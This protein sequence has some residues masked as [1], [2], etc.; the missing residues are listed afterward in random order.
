MTEITPTQTTQTQALQ[1][2]N[3]SDRE[4]SFVPFGSEESIKLNVSI[5]QNLCAVKTKSGRTCS[6]TDAIKFIM[7]CKARGLNPFE[8]DAYLIGY[9][10]RSP[11][12]GAIVP[13]YSLITAHQAFLKRAEL[14]PEYDGMKSGLI[15]L[16]NEDTFR[17]IEGIVCLP[18]DTVYG[19]WCTVFF[20]TRKTP[21]TVRVPLSTYNTNQSRWEKDPHGMIQ[22]V[23]ESQALRKAFPTKMG[24]MFLDSEYNP[25]KTIELVPQI[26]VPGNGL[27]DTVQSED[28]P[29]TKAKEPEKEKAQ[30]P[31]PKP[32]TAKQ[33][34]ESLVLSNGHDFEN[35][36]RWLVDSGA[37]DNADSYANF[38]QIPE[39]LAKRIMRASGPLLKGL[40]AYKQQP[41]TKPEEKA[42]A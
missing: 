42:A 4:V 24:G 6:E 32:Q 15:L 30:S 14:H 40:E 12:G 19:A 34:L 1:R 36:R 27:V 41:A 29:E 7:L 20:K 18:N 22:K 8:G 2:S 35:F 21:M 37:S 3:K 17:D 5:V 11:D 9:D 28:P 38:G 33:N 10:S 23:A 25:H 13:K 26:D 39:D 31:T 16:D